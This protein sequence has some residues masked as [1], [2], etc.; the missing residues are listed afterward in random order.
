MRF[1]IFG[2]RPAFRDIMDAVRTLETEI[3]AGEISASGKTL[4]EFPHETVK[5]RVTG[6]I[7]A[8]GMD[9]TDGPTQIVDPFGEVGEHC[10][11][12]QFA[13]VF[14]SAPMAKAHHKHPGQIAVSDLTPE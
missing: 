4:L 7:L 13:T 12:W 5:Q 10:R 14:A 6:E 2:H 3:N 1:M 11:D 8:Q 9:S